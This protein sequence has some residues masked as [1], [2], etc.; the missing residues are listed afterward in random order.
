MEKALSLLVWLAAVLLSAAPVLG[1]DGF[2][3]IAGGGKAGTQ[4]NSVPYTISSPGLYCLAKNLTYTP[5]TGNAISVTASDVTLDLNGFCLTGPG[6]ASGGNYGITING[7]VTNVEIRNGTVKAFGN[8]GVHTGNGY[9]IRIIGLRASD[10]GASGVWLAGFDHLVAGCSLLNNQTFGATIASGQLKGNQVYDNGGQGLNAGPGST[11]SGNTCQSNV[12]Y[13]ID[14]AAGSSVLDNTVA[15]GGSVGINAAGGCTVA[16][17]TSRGNNAA[18][19]AA[20]DNCL[21]ISNTTQGL[22]SG[23]GSTSVN[24]VVY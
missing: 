18:G 10:N 16:R 5:T 15:D 11:I 20:G 22:I 17:N 13:G 2:Y 8:N 24:N 9:G 23:I 19:I 6:K 3:V 7:G 21:I 1:Q 4:I 14:A 12:G